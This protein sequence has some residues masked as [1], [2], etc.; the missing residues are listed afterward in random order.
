MKTLILLFTTISLNFAFPL[1]GCRSDVASQ[2]EAIYYVHN[3]EIRDQRQY[4]KMPTVYYQLVVDQLG[5]TDQNGDIVSFP[6]WKGVGL[7]K[8]NNDGTMGPYN[9][10]AEI[11][12]L[13]SFEKVQE[14]QLNL[15]GTIREQAI[16]LKR[17][18]DPQP[19]PSGDANW[20]KDNYYQAGKVISQEQ[21][22]KKKQF[23][24]LFS[25]QEKYLGLIGDG[26]GL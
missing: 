12:P 10:S 3:P 14:M 23:E 2:N 8:L 21:F 5:E 13:H 15:D 22:T 18:L 11:Y 16:F 20:V 9:I 4:V 17:V 1:E 19:K 26:L 24:K 25:I 7:C 6:T